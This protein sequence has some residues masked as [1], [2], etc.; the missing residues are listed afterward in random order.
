MYITDLCNKSRCVGV[1][2]LNREGKENEAKEAGRVFAEEASARPDC[3][4]EKRK[5]IKTAG[6]KKSEAP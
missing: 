6:V 4:E 2:V 1:V 3:Q 5:R